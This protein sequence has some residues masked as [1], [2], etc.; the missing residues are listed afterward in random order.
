MEYVKP[1]EQTVFYLFLF[2][3]VF[4]SVDGAGSFNRTFVLEARTA[5]RQTLGQMLYFPFIFFMYAV[6]TGTYCKED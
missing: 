5:E 3:L 1:G 2:F 6:V 4:V